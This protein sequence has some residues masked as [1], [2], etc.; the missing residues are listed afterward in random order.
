MRVFAAILLLFLF[1]ISPPAYAQTSVSCHEKNVPLRKVFDDIYN[2]TGYYFFFKNESRLMDQ[3]VSLDVNNISIET[4]L[5]SYLGVGPSDYRVEAKTYVISR[6]ARTPFGFGLA[7][8]P[9]AQIDLQG[10]ITD[11]NDAPLSGVTIAVEGTR[12]MTTTDSAGNFSLRQVDP[13]GVLL[14]WHVSMDHLRTLIQGR[15][16]FHLRMREKPVELQ[17]YSVVLPL[18]NGY[19]RLPKERSTGSFGYIDHNLINRSVSTSVPDRIENL[20]AGLLTN[21]GQSAGGIPIR[22]IPLIRG[23][24][25]LYANPTP[26]IILDHFPYDGDL[27]NINPNDIESITILKDAA[28]ASIWGVRAG[29]GVIVINTRRGKLNDSSTF[30]TLSP[31]VTYTTSVTFQP[32]PDLYNVSNISSADFIDREKDLYA[33]GY[34][35]TG[36]NIPVTPVVNLLTQVDK[37]TISAPAASA[38]IEAMKTQDIRKDLRK[39]F[40]RGSVNQQHFLQAS[41]STDNAGYYASVGWDHNVYNLTGSSFDR[42]TLR[43]Q[44]IYRIS[45]PLYIETGVNY[46]HTTTRM[47][48][49]PGY[50]YRSPVAHK[51]FYPYASL[52]DAQGA[53]REVSLDYNPDYLTAAG[54]LH[55]SDWSY[56]PLRDRILND[57]TSRMHDLLIN[58]GAR[59]TISPV[60]NVEVKYQYQNGRIDSNYLYDEDAYYTRNL[61]NSFI[62]VDPNSFQLSYPIPQNGG[63]M[64]IGNKEITAHQGR[65]QL[66]YNKTWS[67]R[68]NLTAIA[69]YEIR[70]LVNTA[71]YSR[72]YGYNPGNGS[73]DDKINYDTSYSGWQMSNSRTIPGPVPSARLVDHFISYYTNASFTYHNLYT[74]SVSSREDMANLFGLNYNKKGIPLWSAG[75]AWQINNEHFYHWE[76]LS[77]LKLRATYGRAGN[78]SRLA[79]AYTTAVYPQGGGVTN[80]NDIGYILGLSNPNLRWEQVG[81]FNLG[82]DFASKKRIITG[83]IEYYRKRATD[84]MAPAPGDPTLGLVQTPGT[85]GFYYANTASMNGSGVD[86]QLETHNIYNHPFKWTTNFIISSAIYTVDKYLLSVS[87]G[88]TYLNQNYFS[89]RPG[90]PLY[91]I[92]SYRWAGLDPTNGDPMGYYQGKTSKDWLSINAKTSIDSMVYNG[93]SQP[94]IFGALRNTFRW[95]YFSASFNISYK[96]G[97]YFRKPSINYTDLFNTWVGNGDYARRWQR[98]GDERSTHVPSA[99]YP[100]SDARDFFY[101]NSSVLVEKADHIRLE[102]IQLS[103]DLSRDRYP[104]LPFGNV[105]FYSYVANVGILW[106]ANKSGIDPYYINI[107]KEGRRYSV[108]LNVNF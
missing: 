84:L 72:E 102:D 76:A 66:N 81:L 18:S 33:N 38:Q 67:D 93:S 77:S 91:A 44:N 29:N 62:Q 20:T 41:A 11:M 19:Q 58:I 34:Y 4:F 22:E 60:L 48:G 16:T 1:H 86:I 105:R 89:P 78:I 63:I 49:N 107:P 43:L 68:S 40:Y 45:T 24:S 28:A 104:W 61:R 57:N 12:R 99:A 7:A 70:S 98:S 88:N 26:L 100:G 6:K 17:N 95:H 55:F 87:T 56:V 103:Y 50:N 35:T 30:S 69:G 64:D 23:R 101:L 90:K 42:I 51:G 74:L 82:L 3:L 73:F 27:N 85:P 75:I 5:K 97:Y 31:V 108:G 80:S 39:Y 37:G 14:C 2:Q 36:Y 106:K 47:D 9:E 32:A 71:Q 53:P 13:D 15:T 65:L 10:N 54:N 25:T 92:Y 79:S 8:T 59:Y 52:A 94:T 21:H 96:L 46:T 83:S